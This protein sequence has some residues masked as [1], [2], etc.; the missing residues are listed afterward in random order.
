MIKLNIRSGLMAVAFAAAMTGPALADSHEG[1]G[2]DIPGE[3][4]ANVALSTDYRFRGISQTD[5]G[6]AIQGGFDWSHESG[7]YLG[8]WASNIDFSESIEIDYY[9][10]ITNTV[11]GV[12]YDIGVMYYTYPSADDDFAEFNYVEFYGSLGVE[13]NTVEVAVDLAF[14]PDFFAESDN[15]WAYGGT[16]AVPIPNLEGFKLSGGFH[17]QDV[18]DNAAFGIKDYF[19]WDVGIG[20]TW[21]GLDFD[22]RYVDTDLK[23]SEC[24]GTE[25]CEAQAVFTLSKSF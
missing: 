8:T 16:V 12:T 5:N 10:G 14:S 19:F 22:I 7:V 1:D 23:K 20:W 11:N 21:K 9:G 2:W 6:P 17:R 15:A 25:I 18:K 24:G 4:S 13:V 3:F